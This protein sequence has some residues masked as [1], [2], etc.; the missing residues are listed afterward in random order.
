[1][2]LE[3]YL[4]KTG[5]L[6]DR[7]PVYEIEK[8]SNNMQTYLERTQ[9]IFGVFACFLY[10]F[11][12]LKQYYR[13]D[14]PMQVIP[15]HVFMTLAVVYMF[16]PLNI[17]GRRNIG[18]IL[19]DLCVF[20]ICL[21]LVVYYALNVERLQIRFDGI[22]PIL[23]GERLAFWVGI[24][25]ILEGVRR[26]TGWAL[27]IVVAIAIIYGFGI[28]PLPGWL[29]FSGFSVNHFIEITTL[30]TRGIFGVATNA[31]VSMVFYFILFGAVFS[32]TKG[33]N[34]FIDISLLAAGKL[35][36]GAAKA[37]IFSSALF[38]MISGSAVANVTSTG[39]LT[40]PLMK[41]TGY[42][43]EQAAATEAVASTG[44]QLMPPIM[45]VVAFVMA[46]LLGLPYVRIA[47]AGI[48]PALG[49][50]F[51]LFLSVDLLARKTHIG[52]V[53]KTLII[54]NM[55]PIGQ[56]VHLMLAPVILILSLF[57]GYSV[58]FSALAG[59]VTA[60][61]AP[62][63]RKKTRYHLIEL[64]NMVIDTGKQMGKISVAVTAVGVIIAVSIQSGVAIRFVTLL[65][66]IGENNLL[67][68][69]VLVIVGCLVLGLGLPTVAAYIICAVIF[70]PALTRLGVE[71]LAAHF[72]I[73][74]YS[75]LSM[76]T[77][78]VCLAAYA[79]AGIADASPTRT[80]L[81]AFRLA[82]VMFFLPF[83]FVRD[84]TLLGTGSPILILT[85]LIGIMFATASWAIALQGW[86]GKDL[87]L[88]YRIIFAFFC[89]LIIFEPTMSIGWIA[90][91]VGFGFLSSFLLISSKKRS[92][93]SV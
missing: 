50:Y 25:L 74:Y 17:N 59:T 86:L 43:P 41:R 67:A 82:L 21:Y 34:V 42:S 12:M 76:L 28:V 31:L 2:V 58:A 20:F 32:A 77:P 51:A 38:G 1:M 65:S 64:F 4:V 45:G 71:P 88:F 24:P 40:I 60:L 11:F 26:T 19:F 36:G 44:G 39:V 61:I 6:A 90:G 23:I 79:G 10:V 78:P 13:P 15:F 29:R 3:S 27:I 69:L 84:M 75:V 30:G 54:E 62:L 56:R 91:I 35:K 9:K 83:G 66:N 46:D 14:A 68:S 92:K 87:S 16:V 80:G 57:L 37:A 93:L 47:T 73:M 52:S 55:E 5:M 49:F 85:A 33:G 8:W 53:D 22:D 18:T 48:I 72:F 70:V 63:L 7:M 81:T 89:I